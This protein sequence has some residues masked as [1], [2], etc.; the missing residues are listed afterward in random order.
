[1]G[2]DTDRG[3]MSAHTLIIGDHLIVS[4]KS[5]GSMHEVL[6]STDGLQALAAVLTSVAQYLAA[7]ATGCILSALGSST[8]AKKA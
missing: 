4:Y 5:T 7:R 6:A 8:A 2:R 3:R 1:M